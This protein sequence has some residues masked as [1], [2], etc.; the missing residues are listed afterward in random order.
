MQNLTPPPPACPR[1]GFRPEST[2]SV[3]DFEPVPRKA[4]YD[5]WTPERQR[6]FI[7][8]LA[9]TGSVK[10]ACRRINMSQE[11]AYYL[12]RQNGADSFRAAWAAALDHGVQNLADIAIDRAIEGVSVP[13]FFRGEQVGEKRWYN[14]RLLMFILK[15]HLP[16][17]Y[18]TKPLPEGTKHPD[19]RAR[20]APEAAQA[21][22][23]ERWL[24]ERAHALAQLA[25][26]HRHAVREAVLSLL[27]GD[28]PSAANAEHHA[29]TLEQAIDTAPERWIE[30]AERENAL[31]GASPSVIAADEAATAAERRH[32]RPFAETIA[33]GEADVPDDAPTLATLPRHRD[34]SLIPELPLPREIRLGPA[35]SGGPTM[36]AR[37]SA[38]RAAE[39]RLKQAQQEWLATATEE[40][41]ARWKEGG[42]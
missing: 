11:G 21:A 3:L 9:E 6:A 38:R 41:W 29:R 26:Y 17:R 42:G 1:C 22:E 10:A 36:T 24:T 31:S 39:T 25:W 7:A 30:L 34:G 20:E 5:G 32:C 19:T 14:D 37:E 27:A 4:R 13:V 40:A 33:A 18:G 8:A 12:R 35:M 23:A 16:V 2:V 28:Q 15:H